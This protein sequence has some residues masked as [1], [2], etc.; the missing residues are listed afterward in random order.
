MDMTDRYP[1]GLNPPVEMPEVE[2]RYEL[3]VYC[4]DELVYSDS[5]HS[6]EDLQES[7]LRKADHSIDEFK[8]RKLEALE[9]KDDE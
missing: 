1:E 4:D 2:V 6:E 3:Q 9:E 7:L 5:T 8:G